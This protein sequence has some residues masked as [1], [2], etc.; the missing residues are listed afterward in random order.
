MPC[1]TCTGYSW[2]AIF[3]E[4]P[5]ATLPSYSLRSS[6]MNE[7]HKRRKRR[8]LPLV[9]REQISLAFE[10][11]GLRGLTNAERTKAIIRLSQLLIQ[12]A[13]V[14]GPEIDDER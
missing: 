11:I 3:G 10:S 4:A 13:G 5:V 8:S 12:A 14:V 6:R 7:P 1:V 2:Y 9:Q